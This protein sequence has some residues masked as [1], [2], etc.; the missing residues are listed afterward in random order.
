[1][2]VL[3]GKVAFVTGAARGQGRCHALTLARAGADIIALDLAESIDTVP[4]PGATKDELAETVR[5]IE[6][7]GQR[8]LSV[9]ADVRSQAQLD[10]AVARGIAEFGK[11]DILI[12]NAGIWGLAPFWEITDN[13]WDNMIDINLSGVWRSTK[14]VTPHM[15]ERGSG[16]IIM[17]SSINGMEPC[18]NYAHYVAAKHGVLG[19]MRN[20]ALELAPHGIRC[21]AVCPGAVDTVMLNWQG[22]YDL[23]AGHEGGTRDDFVRAGHSFHALKDVGMLDPQVVAD[24]TLWLVS[25]QASV[26]TGVALPIEAGHMLLTGSSNAS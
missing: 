7:L 19:L 13:E 22:A 1:M 26:I 8:A 14:A 10:E 5:D 18:M 2:K 16:V 12:A 17:T 11:I 25:D 15:I 20:V 24:A 23:F 4:F 3:E 21:N 9:Q 6:A